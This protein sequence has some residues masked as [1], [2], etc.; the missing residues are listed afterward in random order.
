MNKIWI[1]YLLAFGCFVMATSE[2]VVAGIL[3]M[4]AKD[5]NVSVGV[6]GQ[7]VTVYA[8]VL[9]LLHLYCWH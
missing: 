1:V 3:G 2:M 5:T 7:L 8:A 4:I 9:Q 6:A